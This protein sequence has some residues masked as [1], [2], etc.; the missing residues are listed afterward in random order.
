MSALAAYDAVNLLSDP[1]YGYCQITKPIGDGASSEQDLVDHPFL[2]RLRRIHQLQSAWWVFH[3]AEHSRFQHVVGVM[4]LAG[5][6]ATQLYPSLAASC[7]DTPSPQLVEETLRVAG[8]CHD[9]GH[10]PFGHFFDQQVLRRQGLDHEDMGRA[11]VLG[12]LADP[13]ASLRRSPTGAFAPA[14]AVDP[15]AVAWVMAPRELEGFTPPAWLRA[16]KPVLCGLASADNMD[17]V[18][19]DAYVCGIAIGP[20]DVAR[21][22]HYMF[23]TDGTLVLHQ[24]GAG[25]LGMFL[26]SRLYLYNQVYFHR[27]VRRIDLHLRGIFADT[28]ARLL[29]EGDPRQQLQAYLGLT[30]WSVLELVA[31]LQRAPVDD[32]ERRLGERWAQVT[33]RELPWRLAY[34]T[35]E[36]IS[37]PRPGAPA[38][39]AAELGDRIRAELP[40]RWRGA[41][42]EV[43]LATTDPRPVNPVVDAGV[44]SLFDPIRRT[45]RREGAVELLTRLLP[46][47]TTL[48][49]VYTD[50]ADASTAIREA[51]E[52]VLGPSQ[53]ASDSS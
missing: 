6:F 42:I 24:H 34:E 51:A 38:P 8:L 46:L 40:A 23:V 28:V 2:Q 35:Y 31:R 32:T 7:A 27:T 3:T 4:H 29:P 14:E 22:R 33:T 50:S 30:D 15:A 18:P 41:G 1:V 11:M 5:Q 36:E 52:R 13:I 48:L 20:V 17:Y 16:L 9:V 37:L 43:D 10:G 12:P 45:V 19:R 26:N 21:L 39:G 25:A 53:R 49:R 47:H 44:L